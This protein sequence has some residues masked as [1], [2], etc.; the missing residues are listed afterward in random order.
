MSA[1]QFVVR[2]FKKTFIPSLFI[3]VMV[4]DVFAYDTENPTKYDIQKE[5]AKMENVGLDFSKKGQ[6]LNLNLPFTNEAGETKSLGTFF[7]SGKPVL[8]SMVYYRCPSLCSLHMNGVTAAL[9]DLELKAGEDFQWITVSMDASEVNSLAADKK[10]SYIEAFAKKDEA[11]TGWNFLVGNA[12]SVKELTEQLGFSYKWDEE[13]EQFAHSAA[14]YVIG[15]EGQISQIIPGVEFEAKTLKLALIEAAEG[16]VGSFI[17][18]ALMMCFQ[19]N[20]KKNKYTIYAYNVMKIGGLITL[21]LLGVFLV[22][23]WLKVFRS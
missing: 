6:S 9:K 18:R 23:S 17:D 11:R 15:S 22:P 7:K 13:T 19:F 21:L 4:P 12:T 3:L 16:K 8:L 20:P 1:N 5:Q 2:L 14:V 10:E